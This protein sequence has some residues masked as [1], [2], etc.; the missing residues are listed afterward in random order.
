MAYFK[1]APKIGD[2]TKKYKI[3]MNGK[4]IHPYINLPLT[5][6]NVRSETG[7]EP[8]STTEG[9]LGTYNYGKPI[10]IIKDYTQ[11][12]EIQSPDGL[13]SKV[14]EMKFDPN[15]I[16][17]LPSNSFE[18]D[19]GVW[20]YG[21]TWADSGYIGIDIVDWTQNSTGCFVL[22]VYEVTDAVRWYNIEETGIYFSEGITRL[23][24]IPQQAY[25][26]S[27]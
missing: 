18:S 16:F 8:F 24:I 4:K 15:F 6:F 25:H 3:M 23:E 21:I 19:V 12:K 7:H 9:I 5:E 27:Q 1:F 14:C 17:S 22:M 13:I 26:N 20:T 11:S 2:S 10:M